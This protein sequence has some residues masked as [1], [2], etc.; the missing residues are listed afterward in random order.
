MQKRKQILALSGGGFR[1]LYTAR[2]LEKIEQRLDGDLI[3][4]RFD[5]I[6]GTSIGGIIALALAAD[7]PAKKI[8]ETIEEVGP[9][10]FSRR[11]KS[12]RLL[13]LSSL[14]CRCVPKIASVLDRVNDKPYDP[15]PL[16]VALNSLFDNRRISDL[17]HSLIVPVVNFSTGAPKVFKTPHLEKYSV[18]KDR[19]LV[20]V[21]LATSAA[22]VFFPHHEIEG[23]RYVDGG[24]IANGPT[25]FALHEANQ[26]LKWPIEVTH[27]LSIGTLDLG[28]CDS[29]H[30]PIDKGLVGWGEKLFTLT[31]S[32]QEQ[33]ARQM[34]EHQIGNRFLRLDETITKDQS[35]DVGFDKAD[36]A[37]ITTLK[38]R[39]DD[40]FQH[41]IATQAL[42][43]FLAHRAEK[44]I[45]Y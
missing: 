40:R 29:S 17:K 18:D 26:F 33:A 36:A 44:S 45:R 30:T 23:S 14:I 21:G 34:S 4:S 37:A 10:L 2:L 38:T 28:A 8:R 16:K 35:N 41:A 42:Q 43:E 19:S 25:L 12:S 24:L 39:A 5:L 22:P 11:P 13:S 9:K 6:A 31:I 1:G 7:I 32:A 27:M 20:D 3:A 15:A